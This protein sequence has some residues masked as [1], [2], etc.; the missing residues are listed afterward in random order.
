MPNAHATISELPAE[1]QAYL[2][3][4]ELECKQRV[5]IVPEDILVEARDFLAALYED[6]NLAAN[7]SDEVRQRFAEAFGDPSQVAEEREDPE[8]AAKCV[9]G[10]APG[11]RVC[12]TT[13][14]R[15]APGSRIGMIRI[16]AYAHHKYIGGFCQSCGRLRSFRVIQDLERPNLTGRLGANLTAAEL[17]KSMHRPATIV[18]LILLAVL[19]PLATIGLVLFSVLR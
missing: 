11:W 6:E 12:C 1:L 13:C 7:K 9:P 19:L 17:R 5:G 2:E 4:L 14:G 15:S 3:R 10:N 18:F 16:A 8:A